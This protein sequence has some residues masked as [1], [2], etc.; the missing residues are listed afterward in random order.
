MLPAEHYSAP[1]EEWAPD[2]YLAE[3]CAR[4]D[5]DEKR[6]LRFLLR[7]VSKFEG[8]PVALEFGI[9]PTV[10]HL[11]PLA[12]HVSEI[13]VADY[14]QANLDEVRRWQDARPGAHDWQSFTEFVL[15]LEG[16]PAPSR[17]SI[18]RRE[19]LT[20]GRITRYLVGD[21]RV[22]DPLGP[23]R[24]GRYELLLS[25][26]CVDSAVPDRATWQRCMA[27][28]LSLLGP[29]GLFVTAA[30]RRCRRYPVG[31][32]YFPSA[33]I[34]EHDFAGLFAAQGFDMQSV[35]IEVDSVPSQ[36]SFGY[37]SIVMAS[38]RKAC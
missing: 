11:L 1:F 36:A 8:R 30:L 4:V 28:L 18:A 19:A 10:H 33:N 15:A 9:G 29:G 14:L 32:R 38:G 7:E 22:E 24:R 12:P 6:T 21:V 25:F 26:Y 35:T 27:N 16:T 37:E 34:D 3:Y 5:E 17:A 23:G 13:H 20:R 2:E 31:T